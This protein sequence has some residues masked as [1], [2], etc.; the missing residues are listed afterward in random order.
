MKKKQELGILIKSL[1]LQLNGFIR[2]KVI[3]KVILTNN[4]R[5]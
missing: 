3:K 4:K 1:K 5:Q 2:E